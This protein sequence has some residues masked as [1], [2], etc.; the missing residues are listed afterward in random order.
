MSATSVVYTLGDDVSGF[1]STGGIGHYF[2][3]ISDEDLSAGQSPVNVWVEGVFELTASSAWTTAYIGDAVMANSGRVCINS[4]AT[5]DAPIG[6]YI[7]AGTGERSGA[8]ILVNI[9]PMVWRWNSWGGASDSAS[10]IQGGTFPRN[11]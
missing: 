9:R 4:G 7:P 6:S 10:G 11:V 5:G 2:V 8:T 3:G 1:G